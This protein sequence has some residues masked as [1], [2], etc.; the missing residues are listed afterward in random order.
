[1]WDYSTI[2]YLS[3][4]ECSFATDTKKSWLIQTGTGNIIWVIL[5]I[6]L[7]YQ[8]V[9]YT[10]MEGSVQTSGIWVWS[11]LCRTSKPTQTDLVSRR[12]PVP[13]SPGT[14]MPGLD[15]EA[16]AK[17]CRWYHRSEERTM[18]TQSLLLSHAHRIHEQKDLRQQMAGRRQLMCFSVGSSS[19][20][21]AKQ[22]C[23]WHP[24][25]KPMVGKQRQKEAAVVQ[26]GSQTATGKRRGKKW[27][28]RL[29]M[30][31]TLP[32]SHRWHMDNG[33]KWWVRL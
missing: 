29:K 32:V 27:D 26:W 5:H 19:W 17:A 6:Y 12:Y 18:T 23:R 21:Q 10:F 30:P 1:M 22:N 11:R 15:R 14:R 28:F 33:G 3:G 24:P 8:V 2:F 16:D 9:P 25:Q 7:G 31:W 13:T 20:T 4:L